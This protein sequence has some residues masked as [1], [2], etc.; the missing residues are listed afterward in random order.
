MRTLIY[1]LLFLA[2]ISCNSIKPENSETKMIVQKD[3]A[4]PQVKDHQFLDCMYQD[5]YFPKFLVDKCKFILLNLCLEIENQ[6][7]S[8]HE[9]LYR[10]SHAATN[11][12]NYLEDEFFENGS[13]IETAARECLA[14][15]FEFI[16]VAYGFEADVEELIATREW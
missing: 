16:A 4:N 9:E 11:S 12:I 8:N 15:D 1:P 6:K 13:E 5:S 14:M 7:P 2:L 3:L 10:L